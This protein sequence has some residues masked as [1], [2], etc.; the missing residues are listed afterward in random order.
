MKKLHVSLISLLI[1]ASL[2]LATG[3]IAKADSNYTS[4]VH[5][6]FGAQLNPHTDNIDIVVRNASQIGFNWLA[7]EFDWAQ[8]WPDP[9]QPLDLNE[10]N[11]AAVA[12]RSYQANLMVTIKNPPSWALTPQGPNVDYVTA[13]VSSIMQTFPDIIGAIELFP[14]ANQVSQWG[15]PANP[16]QFALILKQA[17]NTIALNNPR[18][19]VVASITPLEENRQEGDIEDLTFLS[20]LYQ[21]GGDQRFPVIGLNFASVNG[22][23][24]QD[25]T[26]DSAHNLRH[27]ENVRRVMRENGRSSDLIWVTSFSWP[28]SLTDNQK[29]AEWL[30]NAYKLLRTQLYIGAAFFKN[31][32]SNDPAN[33][34]EYLISQNII[35]HPAGVLLQKLMVANQAGSYGSEGSYPQTGNGLTNSLTQFLE[36]LLSWLG[37]R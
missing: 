12:S 11:Q 22:D 26:T 16:Q 7:V 34:G 30:F 3:F 15:V 20:S 24:A 10:L 36:K 18:A 33:A 19:V 31:L 32:N 17:Q 9:S 6:G 37:L 21:V 25:P 2:M 8:Q 27:Y 4:A 1:A 13:L 23:P 29:Q 5:F 28:N 35:T 14:G